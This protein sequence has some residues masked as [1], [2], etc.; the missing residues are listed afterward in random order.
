MY[1]MELKDY[2]QKALAEVKRYLASL[3]EWREKK[4]RRQNLSCRQND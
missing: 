4:L 3:V 1:C 2:Q